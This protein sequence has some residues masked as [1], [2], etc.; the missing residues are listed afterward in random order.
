MDVKAHLGF[1]GRMSCGLSHSTASILQLCWVRQLATLTL[2]GSW[3]NESEIRP[4]GKSRRGPHAGDA[5]GSRTKG[6]RSEVR[7][8]AC[9]VCHSDSVTVAGLFPFI[10]YPACP[11]TR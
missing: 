7:V 4:S 11:G 8:E 2:Q 5:G 9:G 10:S 6:R 3:C 1:R